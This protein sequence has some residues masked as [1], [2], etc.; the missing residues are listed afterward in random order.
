MKNRLNL[1]TLLI[2]CIITADAQM[3]DIKERNSFFIGK[4]N[5]VDIS[6]NLLPS[7]EPQRPVTTE[8]I[9]FNISGIYTHINPEISYTFAVSNKF[10]LYAMASQYTRSRLPQEFASR[11]NWD[12][13]YFQDVKTPKLIDRGV[14]FGLAFF[15]TQKGSYAPIGGYF[16]IGAKWHNVSAQYSPFSNPELT[17]PSYTMKLVSGHVEFGLKKPISD[18]LY[19]DIG[20][21][22]ARVL[23]LPKVDYIYLDSELLDQAKYWDQKSLSYSELVKVKFGLGAVF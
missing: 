7:L 4:R 2:L 22:F 18:A 23:P 15:Q 6:L 12:Y 3:V 20:L 11:D 8:N 5:S 16:K 1:L 21:G 13:T 14:G 19:Y 17:I 10:A 9:G